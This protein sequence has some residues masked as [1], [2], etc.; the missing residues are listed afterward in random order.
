MLRLRWFSDGRIMPLWVILIWTWI[1]LKHIHAIRRVWLVHH[2]R[3]LRRLSWRYNI[4]ASRPFQVFRK[5]SF[6]TV[7]LVKSVYHRSAFIFFCDRRLFNLFQ[8]CLRFWRF[9]KISELL[10]ILGYWV[11]SRGVSLLWGVTSKAREYG[12]PWTTCIEY[13]RF[14]TAAWAISIN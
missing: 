4:M 3:R 9:E 12:R 14:G 10:R 6:L 11:C 8:D 1:C 5:F 7:L 2:L 13:I